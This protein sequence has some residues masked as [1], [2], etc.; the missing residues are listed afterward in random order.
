MDYSDWQFLYPPRPDIA[1]PKAL[2]G[3][4]E[5]D[6]WVAQVKL[7]GTCSVMGIAPHRG[8]MKAWNRH[9]ET[10]SAWQ[11]SSINL[12]AFQNLPGDGYYV[13]VAELLHSKGNYKNINY[14]H[15][16]LVADGDFL[17]GYTMTERQD[18][19]QSLFPTEDTGSVSHTVIDDNTWLVKN[20]T[21]GFSSLFDNLDDDAYEGLVMKQP[22]KAL[23]FCLK[24]KSNSDGQV[25][26][27]R[28]SKN[29]HF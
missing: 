16:I 21:T 11:P 23:A 1:I 14:I 15:D 2:L 18:L 25:K 29:Y 26:C 28:P 27:R 10:H 12:N 22:N 17:L 20:H 9:G 7:N 19:L 6:G 13:F 5:K 4:Y 8:S 24:E 3:S